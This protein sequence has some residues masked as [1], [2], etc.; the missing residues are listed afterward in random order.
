[1]PSGYLTAALFAFFSLIIL[2]SEAFFGGWEVVQVEL[3]NRNIP[4]PTTSS[5]DRV[6]SIPCGLN[7][8]VSWPYFS[9]KEM[10]VRQE[11]RPHHRLVV[12]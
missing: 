8:T 1:V 6:H 4:A 12:S 3:L 5:A 2:V 10:H 9:L 7:D 11:K